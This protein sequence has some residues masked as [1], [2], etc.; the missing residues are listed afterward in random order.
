MSVLG[1]KSFNTRRTGAILAVAAM[2]LL[3]A[4][5]T[6]AI[7]GPKAIK[8]KHE[9]RH[10][11]EHIEE[12]WRD[13]IVSNNV[14][15]MEGLLSDDYT[16]IT[17]SGTLETKDKVLANLRAGNAH[18]TSIVLSERK[19][20]FYGTTALV[21]SRADVAGTLGSRNI[22]GSYRYA[23][24]Y[25]RDGQGKWHIVSIESSRISDADDRK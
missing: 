5:L 1:K 22:S 23:H 19:L 9:I 18:F 17:P 10:E 20:R 15:A 3:A 24:V 14:Q 21:N 2:A 6:H 25:A 8:Q 13:A 12:L 4:P 7:Q 11:I 16:G